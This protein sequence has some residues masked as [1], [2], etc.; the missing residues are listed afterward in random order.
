MKILID[1]QTLGTPELHR[2]IGK[3]F[4]EL[5]H[6]MVDGDVDHEWF[7]ALRHQAHF[8]CIKPELRRFIKPLVLAPLSAS[9]EQVEWCRAY[10]RQ[11]RALAV[12]ISAD[13]YWNPNPLMPNVHYPLGFTQC[14]VV[15]TLHDL[16]PRVMPDQFR[17]LLGEALWRDYLARCMEMAGRNCWIVG[18]SEFSGKDFQKFHPDCK[19]QI[20]FVHHASNYSRLWPYRQGDRLSDPRYILYVG[21]F[22][23]RKNMD[24]ALRAYAAFAAL[25]GQNNVRFKVVCA[26]DQ[27]S[28]DRYVALAETLGVANR[29]D[30]LGYVNDDE[31]AFLFRG[32]SVFF[33]PSLYE[34]FGLPVLD[35]LAC[36]LPVVASN[37][38]S[39]PEIAGDH[40]VYCD[41]S[42]VTD[43][44]R[45]LEMAWQ[46]RD[47][48]SPRRSAAVAHAR[49]FRWQQAARQYVDIFNA[50]ADANHGTRG[51]RPSRKPR[52]A[53][54][55]PWPPQKSGV[56][57]YSYHLMPELLAR[58]E[59]TLFAENHQDCLPIPGLEIRS[60]DDYP[61][62]AS[63]FDNAIY[64]LGNGLTHVKIYEHAWRFPGVV[65]LHDFNIHPFFHHGFL[66]HP[67]EALYEVALKEYGDEG[68]AAWANFQNTGSRPEVW[69][70]PMSHPIARRSRAT[71]VHSRWVADRL[72][73][74]ENVV[75]VHHGARSKATVSA[76]EQR[77][78]RKQLSLDEDAYWIGVFGFVN[79]HKRV[80]S[81]L[82]ALGALVSKG[83][84]VRLLIVG[85]VN[86][87]TLDLV[88]AARRIGVGEL[89][90]HEGYVSENRFLEYMQAIDI[91]CNLRYPTMGESSGSMFH[92]LASGKPILVSDYGSF[93]EIPD[94][95]AWKVNPQSEE[96]EQLSAALELLMKFPEARK[97]LGA[98]G[99]K[100]VSSTASLEHV[101]Q[102]YCH[103]IEDSLVVRAASARELD[104]GSGDCSVSTAEGVAAALAL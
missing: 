93:A 1:G 48:N 76:E 2:G 8:D 94:R 99:R 91:V 78:L 14:P 36:G 31:L 90:R 46:Q 86:D 43:M 95:C 102:C 28:R 79:R 100:F 82:A 71:I 60:L 11:L 29:L 67:R 4:L 88:A 21:G 30:L 81:V 103:T 38:S 40:V 101:V 77:L 59:V 65:V 24:N 45:A 85:E 56:A 42:N 50:A 37:T 51:L 17:P 58:M 9:G 61:A 7:V 39:I 6:E 35:A 98:N 27:A 52:I 57:D 25:P 53:Y 70:F 96:T 20:R 19:A 12:S 32:A 16:I 68:D 18:V 63:E 3:V 15:V 66:G 47:P 55:S 89:I 64:H 73:G 72:A 80:E 97:A 26:Y 75:R 44:A 13:V 23:P 33:F 62:S 74:I 49:S 69:Q 104:T 84:S 10:G 22:D 87:D 34:G 5:L 54:L 83:F 41:P 92:C